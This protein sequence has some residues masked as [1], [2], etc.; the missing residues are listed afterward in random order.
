MRGK[1]LVAVI[2]AALTAGMSGIASTTPAQAA[3]NY[4]A[5]GGCVGGL[6]GLD[7]FGMNRPSGIRLDVA[8]TVGVFNV[9]ANAWDTQKVVL[10]VWPY[11]WN[12][13]GWVWTK[14]LVQ[15]SAH[16][17]EYDQ[18]TSS[19]FSTPDRF[20]VQDVLVPN[21]M[22][23][24]YYTLLMRLRW[25]NEQTGVQVATYSDWVRSFESD[26]YSGLPYCSL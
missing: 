4:G 6:S 15:A 26:R 22:G 25:I 20:L 14:Q 8:P 7:Q 5:I 13:S 10:E 9:R 18:P 24:G 12:G 17:S 16:V 11:F 19:Y 3:V 2:A 21:V 23:S 1:T